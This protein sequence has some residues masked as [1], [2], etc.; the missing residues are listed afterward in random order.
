MT[1]DDKKARVA[2]IVRSDP[3]APAW[4]FIA[5]EGTCV[6]FDPNGALF[7]RGRYHLFYIFQDPTLP[8]GGHC[9]GHASSADLVHWT[10]HPT[11]LALE[12]GDPDVGIFSG[13]AFINKAGVPTILYHGVNAGTCVAT[14]VDGGLI[15]WRKSPRNPVIPEPRPGKPGWGVY[16]VFDPHGWVE[17]GVYH[18]ILGGKTKP[19]DVRDTAYL[20]RSNDLIHWDYVRPFYVPHPDWTGPEEDCACPDFFPLGHRHMLLCISHPRGARYYLGRYERGHFIPEEHHRMN[21]PGGSCFAPETLCD[22]RGRRIFWA[23]VPGQRR[24]QGWGV[25]NEPG[26]MTMPRVLTLDER[27]Q[28][29]IDPP[30]ELETLRRNPRRLESLTLEPD[31]PVRPSHIRGAE[32]EI[33]LTAQLPA[34]AELELIVRASPDDAEQTRIVVAP[35]K[36]TLAIDTSRASLAP[37]I[38]RRYP[39]CA[40]NQQDVPVQGA[41]FALPPGEAL[42]LRVFLDRSILEV[43]ANRRQCVTQRLYPTRPDSVE[44]AL[45]SRHGPTV[46]SA[47]NAWD[48]AATNCKE[49]Q[50]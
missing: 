23:W 27:G 49:H 9:W 5:P 7:W 30:I 16:N 37:D 6:P 20:F 13:N 3:H 11:A 47:F 14:A 29:L 10:Y 46:V 4:H 33:E 35:A 28:L 41:P 40:D 45:V 36:A 15:Q 34:G 12:Q 32:L 19:D 31:R 2:E 1:S 42:H 8:H 38:F 26:V 18:V 22:D 25:A 48:L 24:G 44:V 39:V 17:D 50:L 21:W 43:Y